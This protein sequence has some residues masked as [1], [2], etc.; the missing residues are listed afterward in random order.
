M[1]S[2]RFGDHHPDPPPPPDEP[3]P[4]LPDE[5]ESMLVPS[6]CHGSRDLVQ[7]S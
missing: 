1:G 7:S 5:L 6:C 3:P 4:L 2:G